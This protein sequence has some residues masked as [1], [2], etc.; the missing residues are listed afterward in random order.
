VLA[1][2]LLAFTTTLCLWWLYFKDAAPAA[3]H[4]FA[5]A[6]DQIRLR[7]RLAADAYSLAHFP[8]IAGVIYFALAWV[9]R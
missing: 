6:A 7:Q 8:L 1:T 4:A 3:G 9:I 5:D 2:A